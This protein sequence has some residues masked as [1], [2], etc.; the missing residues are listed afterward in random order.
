MQHNSPGRKPSTS[1]MQ[2]SKHILL[3]E[4]DKNLRLLLQHLLEEQYG[5]SAVTDG[6]SA[7]NWLALGNMPDLIMADVDMPGMNS[8]A[9]L[10]N[11]R[12]SGFYRHIPV[13]VMSGKSDLE[14]ARRLIGHGAVDVLSKPF[15]R[16]ELFKLIQRYAPV[17]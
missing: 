8:T 9:L 13:I 1:T 15:P 6:H 10:D 16:E 11:L 3:I 7:L 5:V 4:D 17:L 12:C 2:D 14:K